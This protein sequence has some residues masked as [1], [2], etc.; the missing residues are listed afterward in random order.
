MHAKP[1][2]LHSLLQIK[3]PP[4]VR[5]LLQL[6]TWLGDKAGAHA[7]ELVPDEGVEVVGVQE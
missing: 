4:I 5:I 6:Q 2:P 7:E 1:H 3:A